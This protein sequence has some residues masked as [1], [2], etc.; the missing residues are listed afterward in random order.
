MIL[1]PWS[2]AFILAPRQVCVGDEP[3]L[4]QYGGAYD[5]IIVPALQNIRQALVISGLSFRIRV[6][7][8]L[9]ADVL[10]SSFPPSSGVFRPAI[11]PQLTQIAAILRASGSPFTIN[12]HPFFSLLAQ[13]RQGYVRPTMV[14]I[15][16]E[17]STNIEAVSPGAWN[18]VDPGSNLRYGNLFDGTFDATVFAL[19]RI[20]FSDVSAVPLLFRGHVRPRCPLLTFTNC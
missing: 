1:K 13:G 9:N 7:V 15:D 12:I 4:S 20:G 2:S 3:F 19:R 17:A 10:A 5:D 14:L 6:T 11:L 8:P 18:Y 16:T